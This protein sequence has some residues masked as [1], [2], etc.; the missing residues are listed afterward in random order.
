MKKVINDI[1]DGYVEYEDT[2]A[3]RD[4]VFEEV[5]KYFKKHKAFD[6]EVIC[7]DDDCQIYASGV[8]ANI[9]DDIIKFEY[10]EN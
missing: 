2:Q 4:A 6:G 8:F 3:V 1:Y 5:M 10:I 7:Q 9:A